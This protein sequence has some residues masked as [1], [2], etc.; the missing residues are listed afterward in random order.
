M[1]PYKVLGIHR[2]STLREIRSRYLLLAREYHPDR[3]KGK[4]TVKFQEIESAYRTVLSAE[5]KTKPKPKTN[6]PPPPPPQVPKFKKGQGLDDFLNDL[7]NEGRK[8]T[9]KKKDKW[10]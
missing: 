10:S 3:N 2:N 5:S 9:G 7:M 8:K 1:D 4:T 6:P